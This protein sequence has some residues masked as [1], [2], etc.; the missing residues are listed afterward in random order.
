MYQYSLNGTWSL[1][2]GT[3]GEFFPANVPGS[4]LNNLLE[5]GKISNP[6]WR[7]EEHSAELTEI[8][9]N[10]CRQSLFHPERGSAGGTG[11]SL[12][13]R[14]GH[15]SGNFPQRA[16]GRESG[17]YAPQ[18]EISNQTVFAGGKFAGGLYFFCGGIWGT[19]L[20]ER[21]YPIYQYWHN[22]GKQLPSKSPLYVWMGLGPSAS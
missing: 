8:L 12:P 10:P 22:A 21:G 2:F 11:F 3:K 16:G 7:D 14:F 9:R 6:F 19:A 1:S 5:A 15:P 17:Q 13:G 4:L 18:M 20:S